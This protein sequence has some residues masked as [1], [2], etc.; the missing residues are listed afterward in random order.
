MVTDTLLSLLDYEFGNDY[1]YEVAGDVDEAWEIIKSLEKEESNLR[2][3]ISDWQ[4]PGVKGDQFLLDVHSKS[5][6]T[7]LIM[8]SGYADTEAVKRLE[9]S[10]S[11]FEFV[12]KPWSRPDFIK[13]VREKLNE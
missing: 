8:L 10:I 1:S 6:D 13:L 11:D 7:K 2:L 4:M 12:L 9:S 5:T 3:V